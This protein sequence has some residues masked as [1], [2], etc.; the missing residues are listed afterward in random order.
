MD[1]KEEIKSR[2]DIAELIGEYLTLKPAGVSR[3]R[4]LCPFH[5]EKTPSF[6]VST[7]KQIWHCFGCNEGGDCFSFVMKMEGMDFPEALLHLGKKVGVEVPRFAA[8]DTNEKQRLIDMH[9]LAR[10]YF[11]KVLV[12]SGIAIT[13]REYVTRRGIRDELA[14]K[15]SIGF[16]PDTWDSLV[17]FLGTRGYSATE[18]EKAGLALR[19]KDG[20][21]L[22]DR[23]RNRLMIPLR[24]QHGNTVGFTG[25]VFPADR[26][27]KL[28]DQR[29]NEGFE[30]PKYLNS[31]E[32]QIYHK[33]RLLFG[34]DLAKQA[35]KAEG[36]VIIVEGNLDVVASHK[37][38]V[39]NV[40]ASSGTAL[41][42][43]HL[44]LL[45][46]FTKTIVF[47]FDA[48]AA[49]FKAAQR[50]IALARTAGLDVRVAVLPADAG[51]D[52]D[53]AVQKDPQL[54]RDATTKTVPIMQYV[55]ERAVDGR[56]L[57]NIDDKRAVAALVL[58]ELEQISDVVEREHWLQTVADILRIDTAQLR[59]V[60]W[61]AKK[62]TFKGTL[63]PSVSNTT[64]S[65]GGSALGGKM[66][67]KISRDEQAARALLAFFIQDPSARP[68]LVLSMPESLIPSDP[69]R[70]LYKHLLEEYHSSQS[71]DASNPSF[72][73]RLSA[74][75]SGLD[76][77]ILQ[78]LAL[79][80]ETLVSDMPSDRVSEQIHELLHSLSSSARDRRRKAIEGD[81]RRAES[82]GDR[83]TVNRLIEELNSLR[84]V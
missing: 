69:L 61:G 49:G 6:H 68:I 29:K 24:D 57:T 40:V 71:V 66:A 78:E 36:R 51:K 84:P 50:G 17:G 1:P 52:P 67:I 76:L 62:E 14:E 8:T 54:W 58:P 59:P 34:L 38:G 42:E 33:G 31:P 80:G 44:A 12:E 25:R 19:R 4:A 28:E 48:D 43:E 13:V 73:G 75:L 65:R 32:T 22:Y 5:T 63:V 10:K 2:L 16:A 45:K 82:A 70:I 79:L 60:T 15:F 77:A 64:S 81:M 83:D 56:D 35:I 20:S 21:G 41:T 27:L 72:Y 26:S 53:D 18:I 11:R 3:F 39:E 23:F 9:E 74:R 55:I 47:S 46:R 37:A 7:D 30:N